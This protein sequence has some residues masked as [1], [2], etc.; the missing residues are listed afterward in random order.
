MRKTF[1]LIL[2]I[3]VISN[4]LTAQNTIY[5][6]SDPSPSPDGSKIVFAYEDDLWTIPSSGGL[7]LRITAMDGRESEPVYSP[8]G[9]WIA[10]TG[11]QDGN[12]N[13]YVISAEGGGITQ[14]TFND[15]SDGVDSWS[16]DSKFIYFRSNR[17]NQISAYKVT[18][19]GG[20]PV[21]LFEGYKNR[22]HNIAENPLDGSIYFNESWESS[23]MTNRKR[24]KGSYNPDIK[25]YNFATGE[26]EVHTNYEGK[27]LWP[28][29]DRKGTLYFVSDRDNGEYNLYTMEANEVKALTGF[30]TSIKKP[31]VS[32][33]GNIITFEKDYR[34]FVYD[35]STG[36]S[37]PVPI[38]LY[39]NKVIETY[40]EY[41]ITDKITSFNVSPDGKKIVFVSRGRMFVS[42]IKGK[43]VKEIITTEDER[44][45]EVLWLKDNETVLY[46]RTVKGWLNLFTIK[47][48]GQSSEKVLTTDEQN[49]QEIHFN[50]DKSMAVY[51]SGRNELRILDTESM[52]SKTV[53]RDEFWALY[54]G[55][56]YFSPDDKFIAYSAYR[57]FEQDIFVYN[58]EKDKSEQITKTGVSETSPYWSP[59]GKYIYFESDRFHPGYPRGFRDAEIF[60]VA[61]KK[62]DKEFKLDRYDKLFVKE[63]KK[64]STKPKVEIDFEGLND[65]W[66]G[67]ATQPSNQGSPIVIQK[68]EETIVLF[69]SN[70]D[71]E[72]R[73][74]WKTVIK[75]FE[76]SETKKIEGSGKYSGIICE[77]KDKYYVLAGG[78]INELDIS[79]NKLTKISISHKFGK[80][81]NQEFEQMFYETWANLGENYYDDNFHGA[82]WEKMKN[83][84]SRFLPYVK[85]RDNLRTMLND[86]LGE[87]NSSHLGFNSSGDE[88]KTFYSQGTVNTGIIFDN[89]NPFIVNRVV[90]RSAADKE[91][92]DIRRGDRLIAVNGAEVESQINRE[93]YF[94]GAFREEEF[95]LTFERGSNKYDVKVHPESRS[96]LEAHLYDEWVDERQEMVNDKSNNRIAYVHMKNM[97]SGELNN[98]LI[99]M[100][101]EAHYKDALI[102]DI[103][104]NRGG[105]VHNDVLQFLSQKSYLQW[106][107]R[108][109]EL[110]PQPN[111]APSD[112]P[113]VLLINEQSLSDAE[114]TA[115]GFKTLK[116]GT[117]V[118]TETYRWII[119]TSGKSLVDGSYY[120]LPSWGCYTLDGDDIETTGVKPD[121][122]IKNNVVDRLKNED[123]QLDKAIEIILNQLQK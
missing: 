77:A 52:K 115:Q 92:K 106:K 31:C 103:R 33:D 81:L 56:A 90:K 58:I 120:R 1:I 29:F 82:D 47:V 30:D 16:W 49:N 67:I 107:Y 17:Y 68:D 61:L 59:D 118:G 8:D 117:I 57:N 10:F 20:T 97:G 102:F 60:R 114:M 121:V 89:N 86:M 108:G 3:I 48:S 63:E 34:V 41:E 32:A 50:T 15:A 116:L 12:S 80:N 93:K 5:F 110:S 54:P 84:Y 7:A 122:F 88:E 112:K 53:V 55:A 42:D 27:D 113:I 75:P 36:S 45:I 104:Y 98:F 4:L 64:D 14:L 44:V 100:S 2:I 69:N 123:P 94:T 18:V 95:A 28:A 83:N 101:N 43:F 72:S 119:F 65:R 79:G 87:L 37:N 13:V 91:D 62:Y 6:T 51:F 70:H 85:T 39:E 25:S 96:E 24:Y 21:K 74:I 35:V 11:R 109:G 22:Q 73:A 9:K 19:T 99:E 105:N 23:Y 66:E 76:K 40:K 38:S 78:S 71:S 26:Y 46:N 111:F